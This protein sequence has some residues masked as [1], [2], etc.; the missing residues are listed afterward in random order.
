[1]LAR[2][3]MFFT[4]RRKFRSLFR[5]KW[6]SGT[7]S[8]WGILFPRRMERDWTFPR[9]YDRRHFWCVAEVKSADAF[10]PPHALSAGL[11]VAHPTQLHSSWPPPLSDRYLLSLVAVV[12][13]V[14]V[15]GCGDRSLTWHHR[16][17]H[18]Q[19]SVPHILG[20]GYTRGKAESLSS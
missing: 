19:P 5:F 12:V 11:L 20:A 3:E 10:P 16:T 13:M 18:P 17:I 1:M 6:F 2:R 8:R 15:C 9:V 14:V 7:R 4:C